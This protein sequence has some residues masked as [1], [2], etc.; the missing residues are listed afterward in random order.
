MR[1]RETVTTLGTRA[2]RQAAT[3]AASS[4]YFRM[5][6]PCTLPYTLASSGVMSFD[7]VVAD[8]LIGTGGGRASLAT[9][10]AARLAISG[11]ARKRID[12]GPPGAAVKSQDD[13]LRALAGSKEVEAFV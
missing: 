4:M 7:I 5:A 13:R 1:S 8:W 11:L 9:A 3:A 6:P 2:W 10:G 12:L